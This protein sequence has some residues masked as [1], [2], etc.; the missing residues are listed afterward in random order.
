[1]KTMIQP[2]GFYRAIGKIKQVIHENLLFNMGAVYI[3][4]ELIIFKFLI[5]TFLTKGPYFAET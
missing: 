4:E 1:M 3:C 5:K 2:L